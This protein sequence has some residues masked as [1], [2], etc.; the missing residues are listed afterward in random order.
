MPE[1][2]TILVVTE[3]E[4][5]WRDILEETGDFATS[6]PVQTFAQPN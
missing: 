3:F 4:K 1:P 2:H 6:V 5:A